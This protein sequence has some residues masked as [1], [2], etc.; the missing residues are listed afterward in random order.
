MSKPIKNQFRSSHFYLSA[1]LLAH[2]IELIDYD[3]EDQ[4][5]VTFSFQDSKELIRLVNEF[6]FGSQALVDAP[7]FISAIKRLKSIVHDG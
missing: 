1:Y 5:R 7:T 2:G 4:G 3:R 6:T